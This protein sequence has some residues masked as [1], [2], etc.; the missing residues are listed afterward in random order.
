MPYQNNKALHIAMTTDY[1]NA[2]NKT[3]SKSDQNLASMNL[4]QN[5]L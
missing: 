4:K 1:S 2:Q 3:Q 5:S